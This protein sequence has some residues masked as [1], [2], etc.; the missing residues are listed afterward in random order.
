MRTKLLPALALSY[1][2]ASLFHFAH[3]AE[4]LGDYPNMPAWL[5]PMLV[6]GTW[7]GIT[8]VGLAGYFL[9]RGGYPLAGLAVLG[10]YGAQGLD[11]LGHYTLAPVSAHS[12]AMNLSIWLEAATGALLLATAAT[13]ALA[14]MRTGRR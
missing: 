8:A 11:A 10:I 7:L 12:F 3:N 4:Y 2:A 14:R 1:G 5:S 13:M 6:Y 9:I